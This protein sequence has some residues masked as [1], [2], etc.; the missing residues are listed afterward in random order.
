MNTQEMIIYINTSLK[1]ISEK[2][3]LS[4]IGEKYIDERMK[5]S[6]DQGGFSEYWKTISF[7]EAMKIK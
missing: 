6:E 3:T 7:E 4:D 2:G 1:R 5:K